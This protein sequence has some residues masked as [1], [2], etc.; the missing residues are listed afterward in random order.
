MINDEDI[1]PEERAMIAEADKFAESIINEKCKRCIDFEK[2]LVLTKC[3]CD[4][5]NEL[6]AEHI[7]SK[8]E[9]NCIVAAWMTR[10]K[11]N[12]EGK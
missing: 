12:R 9:Q 7:S 8:R 4:P 10:Q 6:I 1:T 11:V 5:I 2:A 3:I